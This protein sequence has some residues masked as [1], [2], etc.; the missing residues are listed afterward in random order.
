MKLEEREE[1]RYLVWNKLSLWPEREH[2][3]STVSLGTAVLSPPQVA[4]GQTAGS[5]ST[6]NVKG[7]LRVNPSTW[8]ESKAC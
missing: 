2:N 4:E 7:E 3:V 5:Q 8:K 6:R 1:S